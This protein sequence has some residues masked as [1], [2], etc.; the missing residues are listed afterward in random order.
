MRTRDFIVELTRCVAVAA[1]NTEDIRYATE[2]PMTDFENAMQVAAARACGARHIV[3]S[4]IRDYVH[5]PIRAVNP[6]EALG[7]LF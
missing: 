6:E 7:G 4:N 5:L 3:T 2:L 1:T